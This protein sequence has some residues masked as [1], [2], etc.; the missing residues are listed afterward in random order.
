[1]FIIKY[2]L[3]LCLPFLGNSLTVSMTSVTA[4]ENPISCESLLGCDLLIAVGEW[5]PVGVAAGDWAI[6]I[7]GVL[8]FLRNDPWCGWREAKAARTPVWSWIE[9]Q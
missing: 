5:A 1:M 7:E 6:W 9:K 2:D 4:S 3:L 8:V